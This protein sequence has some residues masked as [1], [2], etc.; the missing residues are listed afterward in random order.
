[1]KC[2]SAHRHNPGKG[3]FGVTLKRLSRNEKCVV[4]VMKGLM[5]R[6]AANI[7]AVLPGNQ[8]HSP[9]SNLQ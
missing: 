4:G 2:L 6:H 3:K 1:M 8:D 7:P 9:P 5:C